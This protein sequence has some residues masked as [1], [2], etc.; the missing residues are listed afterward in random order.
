MMKQCK[1]LTGW[2]VSETINIELA[3]GLFGEEKKPL[4]YANHQHDEAMM[5]DGEVCLFLKNGD[6]IQIPSTDI[7]IKQVKKECEEK[8]LLEEDDHEIL[9]ITPKDL[10]GMSFKRFESLYYGAEPVNS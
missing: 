7:T 6:V 3:Y 8:V 10:L 5:V 4:E 2:Q 9:D 1:A